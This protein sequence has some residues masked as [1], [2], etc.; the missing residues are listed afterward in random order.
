MIY[1]GT[2][3]CGSG[4][5]L[6]LIKSFYLL[7]A[8]LVVSIVWTVCSVNSFCFCQD[9]FF[10]CCS[11]TELSQILLCEWESNSPP[12]VGCWLLHGSLYVNI[13]CDHIN[14]KPR[15]SNMWSNHAI[16][17]SQ[18]VLNPLWLCEFDHP[19][20][21]WSPILV[22]GYCSSKL[23]AHMHHGSAHFW[24]NMQPHCWWYKWFCELSV[25]IVVKHIQSLVGGEQDPVFCYCCLYQ[26]GHS[27]SN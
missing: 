4:W 13:V 26:F 20:E 12:A 19:H 11:T 7:N 2:D 3:P 5:P 16:L 23:F 14:V 15:L 17:A 10:D 21:L 18:W 25:I 9:R 24:P 6:L 22:R 27:P 8:S 1:C